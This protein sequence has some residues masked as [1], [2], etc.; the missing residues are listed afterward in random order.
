MLASLPY[1]DLVGAQ[2]PL[3]LLASTPTRIAALVRGWDARRWAG[4]YAP[5]KWTAAQLILHL[6]HDEIGWCNRVR[7]ALT[8]EGYVVQPYDGARWVAQETPTDP[9]TSLAAPRAARAVAR[10]VRHRHGRPGGRGATRGRAGGAAGAGRHRVRAAAG[11]L[12]DSPCRGRQS[13]Q[14]HRGVAVRP[15]HDRLRPPGG[16]GPPR[17]PQAHQRPHD[18]P[19]FRSRHHRPADIRLDG[20]HRRRAGGAGGRSRRGGCARRVHVVGA[21]LARECVA[22]HTLAAARER[23]LARPRDGGGARGA[24]PRR[25]RVPARCGTRPRQGSPAGRAGRLGHRAVS[26]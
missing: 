12:T 5:G 24:A 22:R 23:G 10:A 13:R 18:G 17:E 19:G 7:L 4:T 6:A 25:L 26:G 15:A 16:H 14:P 3:S 2:D 11:A 8:V 9:D 20:L 21:A 1:A